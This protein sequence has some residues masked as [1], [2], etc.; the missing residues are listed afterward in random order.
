MKISI[1]TD[2]GDLVELINLDVF[3]LS[4]PQGQQELLSQITEA[5]ENWGEE[6]EG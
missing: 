4:N 3:D 2:H 6:E 1:T 5:I